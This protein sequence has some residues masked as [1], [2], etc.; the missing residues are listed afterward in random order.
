[1]PRKARIVVPEIPAHVVHR[2]NRKGNVFFD[3]WDRLRYL[4]TLSA[5]CERYRVELWAY[6][7]M[8]NHIHLLALPHTRTALAEAIGGAHGHYARTLNLRQGWSGHAWENR[9]HSTLLDERHLWSAVRYVENNPVRAG[10]VR[11]AEDYRWSSARAHCGQ[12]ADPWLSIARP[13]PGAMD[14]WADWLRQDCE[15]PWSR[16]RV[17]SRTG[18]PSGSAEFIAKLSRLVGRPLEARPRG[19]PRR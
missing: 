19:L 9:F 2:G 14:R 10:M 7:L 12:S 6:C 5:Y 1:M 8:T 15:E 17:N 4:K 3:D 11:R 13:F 16:L 18:N